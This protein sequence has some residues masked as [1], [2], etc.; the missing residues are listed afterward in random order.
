M[1]LAPSSIPAWKQVLP[2]SVVL[3]IAFALVFSLLDGTTLSGGIDNDDS[4]EL[5]YLRSSSQE[6][7]SLQVQNAT[8]TQCTAACC[9]QFQKTCESGNPLNFLPIILQYILLIFLVASSALVAGLTLGLMSLDTTGLE[10]VMNGDDEKNARYARR[11]LPVRKEGNQLLCTLVFC[12]IAVNALFSIIMADKTGG[13]IGLVSSTFIIVIFGEIIP[14]AICNRHGLSIGSA[15]LPIVRFIM[16]VFYPFAKPLAI[17]LDYGLGKELVTTYSVSELLKLLEIHVDAN[18]MDKDTADTMTGA[19]TF[20]NILVRD[21]MTPLE[22]V[23]MLSVDERLN[24]ETI[25]TI[26][27]KGYSRIPV[28]EINQVCL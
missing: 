8:A 6:E 26:F 24:F 25:G 27:K 22:N 14:Q 4:P 9:Q 11:I 28:Y 3:G 12:N 15:S 20:K 5:Y 19:L 2:L 10:I 7:R 23:F 16:V 18:A 17:C 13:I 1:K 21:V